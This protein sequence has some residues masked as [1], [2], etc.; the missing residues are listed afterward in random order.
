M[1]SNQKASTISILYLGKDNAFF[2]RIVQTYQKNFSLP[3]NPISNQQQEN[4]DITIKMTNPFKN[5]SLHA[6][7]SHW[8]YNIFPHILYVDFDIIASDC[9]SE[10]ELFATL[11]SLKKHFLFK[12]CFIVGVFDNEELLE[13]YSS[14]LSHGVNFTLLKQSIEQLAFIDIN[15]IVFEQKIAYPQMATASGLSFLCDVHSAVKL[16]SITPDKIDIETDLAIDSNQRMI[17]FSSP[18]L[19]EYLNTQCKFSAVNYR[20]A[21]FHHSCRATMSLPYPEPWDEVCADSLSKD[22][23]E[24]WIASK[25]DDLLV[26]ATSVIIID[27]NPAHLVDIVKIQ[28][29][30]NFSIEYSPLFRSR[31]DIVALTKPQIIVFNLDTSL[32]DF[33]SHN[34]NAKPIEN[35]FFFPEDQTIISDGKSDYFITNYDQRMQNGMS[36]LSAVIQEAKLLSHEPLIIIFNAPSTSSAYQKSYNYNKI[37]A[38]PKQLNYLTLKNA[39]DIYQQKIKPHN[40]LFSC[41]D[42]NSY[43]DFKFT[44]TITSISEHTITFLSPFELPK[45]TTIKL[46]IPKTVLISTIEPT[47]E[48]MPIPQKYHYMGVVH[49]ASEEIISSLRVFVN[50]LLIEEVHSPKQAYKPSEKITPKE[51]NLSP[52]MPITIV[53]SYNEDPS[54]IPTSMKSRFVLKNSI[55]KYFKRSKF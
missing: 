44:I 53:P 54:E 26:A 55:S 5:K 13:R 2:G 24:T 15:Y 12:H 9:C 31:L 3:K 32:N 42:P 16:I 10:E 11:L 4:V 48:L 28:I 8:S 43:A 6:F 7:F 50:A 1:K 30:S 22:T 39:L 35:I 29:H 34:S 20:K 23:I 37:T 36:S 41:Y 25:S 27:S 40:Q 19:S 46:N 33:D 17:K 21:Y 51:K 45:V 18:F 49:G 52:P 47:R 38:H 14:V